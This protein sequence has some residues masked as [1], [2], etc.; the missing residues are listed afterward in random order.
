MSI[1]MT[2]AVVV[3]PGGGWG[4]VGIGDGSYIKRDACS[5]FKLKNMQ[6]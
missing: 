6:N 1:G 5:Y 3:C 4:V 2:A